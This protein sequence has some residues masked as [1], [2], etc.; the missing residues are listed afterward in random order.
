MRVAN[1]LILC[2]CE[3][4]SVAT[5]VD[6]PLPWIGENLRRKTEPGKYYLLF[7]AEVQCVLEMIFSIDF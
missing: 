5:A 6:D 3:E 7:C 2:Q 1:K 4:L